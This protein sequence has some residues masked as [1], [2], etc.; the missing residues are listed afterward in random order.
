MS[1]WLPGSKRGRKNGRPWM[2]S[3]WV[4]LIRMCPRTGRSFAASSASPKSCAPV[5]QSRMTSVPSSARA[6]THAV[7]PPYRSVV[8]PGLASEPRVPQ[9][10]ICI[11]VSLGGGSHRIE[12]RGAAA[13]ARHA[14]GREVGSARGQDQAHR[15]LDAERRRDREVLYRCLRAEGSR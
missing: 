14:G 6:S 15:H 8:G 9:N 10:R 4:W 13:S 1:H 2:W 5:P 7:L 12:Y 3:Q 11:V